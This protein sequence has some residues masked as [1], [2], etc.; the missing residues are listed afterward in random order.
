MS[1][2]RIVAV[3][4]GALM[5]FTGV[6]CIMNPAMTY[7]T[8]VYIAAIWL[9]ITGVISIMLSNR[10]RALKD[11]PATGPAGKRWWFPML[12]GVL[13]IICGVLGFISP[14]GLIVAIGIQ[15]GLTIMIA[16]MNLIAISA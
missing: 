15:M 5:I 9:I 4:L 7:M 6:F 3:I 16:G 11:D 1:A 13:L 2:S 8:I 12:T 10:L 14:A